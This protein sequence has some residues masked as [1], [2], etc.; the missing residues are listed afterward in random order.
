MLPVIHSSSSRRKMG[1]RGLFQWIIF[2]GVLCVIGWYFISRSLLLSR[3]SAQSR[4]KGVTK[5]PLIVGLEQEIEARKSVKGN[6]SFLAK[7]GPHKEVK[8]WQKYGK[9]NK[10]KSH[11]RSGNWLVGWLARRLIAQLSSWLIDCLIE[12]F[13]FS[14]AAG[15]SN[16]FPV[17]PESTKIVLFWTNFFGTPD[18]RASL[19]PKLFEGCPVHQCTSTGDRSKLS[20]SSAVIFHALDL[21]DLPGPRRSGQHYVFLIGESPANVVRGNFNEFRVEFFSSMN[22]IFSN[23]RSAMQSINQSINVWY[24]SKS[25]NQIKIKFYQN[26]FK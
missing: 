24:D 12:A 26:F 11:D 19:G 10:P 18:A 6:F 5:D 22:F 23:N 21:G 16:L 15:A 3:I 9:L 7:I 2:G 13:L 25:N 17:D 8:S 4:M 1:P 14:V 20:T